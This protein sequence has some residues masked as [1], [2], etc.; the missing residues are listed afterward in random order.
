MLWR[1]Q[2]EDTDVPIVRTLPV[3]D[4]NAP[5]P[6]EQHDLSQYATTEDHAAKVGVYRFTRRT[7]ST[8]TATVVLKPGNQTGL[9]VEGDIVQ[10]YVQV[11]TSREPVSVI[12]RLYVVE[13]IGHSLSGEETLSLSHL[14]VN[15]SGQS[16]IALA[17]AAATGTGTI[18]P[19]NRT[20]GS[21]DLPGA[22]SDTSV[23]SRSTSGSPFNEQGSGE[24][25]WIGDATDAGGGGGFTDPYG[26]GGVP[27]DAPPDPGAS[28]TSPAVRRAQGEGAIPPSSDTRCPNGYNRVTGS[29]RLNFIDVFAVFIEQ[30]IPF[31][32]TKYPD[33][34]YTGTIYPTWGAAAGRAW[35]EYVITWTDPV[36]G[37]QSNASY[38]IPATP[39]PGGGT[40]VGRFSLTA[41]S[42]SC[43]LF[44]P[45]GTTTAGPTVSGRF[46]KVVEG[47][48]MAK[49]SQKMYGTTS[50]ANDIRTAN[51]GLMGLDNWGLWPGLILTIPA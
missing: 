12:N 19:S 50:R 36:N 35:D 8:H 1:Q 45:S 2:H 49:I 5:G 44:G 24:A 43:N 42:Y 15:S 37:P 39:M 18:L 22:S 20:G 4:P 30:D 14:P 51:P 32:A 11:V 29:F 25:Y 21:C 48:S 10:V 41:N 9:I 17:V 40:Y 47:D 46:Y 7:L 34:T 3:G 38:E 33:I 13:S 28:P 16:L 23:P 6:L 26:G 27:I 31:T